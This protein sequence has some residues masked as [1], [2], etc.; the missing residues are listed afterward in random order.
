MDS[1]QL[2]FMTALLMKS[3]RDLEYFKEMSDALL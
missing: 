3:K 1:C 2:E